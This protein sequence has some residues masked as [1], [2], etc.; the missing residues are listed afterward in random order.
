[1]FRD[2][3]NGPGE[4]LVVGS[5]QMVAAAP[6]EAIGK[7]ASAI[8]SVT[9]I[10]ADG[11]IVRPSVGDFVYQ[12]DTIET[13]ADGA[14]GI[15]FIDGTAFNVSAASRLVLNEFSCERTGAPNSALLSL[16]QGAFSFVAGKIAKTGGLNIHT[17]LATIRGKTQDRGIGILTLA[18]LTFAAIKESEAASPPDAFLDDG[19]ITYKDLPHGTFEITTRDGRVIIADDPGETIVVDPT[20]SVARIP[21][22]SSRMAELQQAQQT[23]LATLS[24]GQQ[25]AAP[26]GSST[27][28]FDL[29]V[30]LTPIN[31]IQ[32][33]SGPLQ[34]AITTHVTAASSGFIDV[35]NQIKP[36]VVI[37]ALAPDAG[38]RTVVE[39]INTTG[40]THVDFAPSGMLTFTGVQLAT[41]SASLASM[42]WSGGAPPSDLGGVLAGAFSL[43]VESGD[44][45]SGSIATTFGA[46]DR[47]FDFLA[48]GETLTIVYDVTVTDDLGNSLTQPV[49]ITIVGTNDAPVLAADAS[50]PH[51]VT[52]GLSTTGTLTFT[53]VDLN[54]HHTVTTSVVSATWSGGALPSGMAAWLAGALSATASDT[55]SGSGSV[56]VTFSAAGHGFDFLGAGQTLEITYNVTVTDGSGV[57][58][59]QPMTVTIAGTNDV[60]VIGGVHTGSVTEDINV[61]AGNISTSGGLT[62]TDADQGES[63]FAVQTGTL[64]SNGHGNFTLAADGTWT[65]TANN[66]QTAIQQLNAG[67]SITD[68]FTAVSSD[69]T[70]SQI[71]TVTITGTNDGPAIIAAT[72]PAAIPESAGSS[73]AQDIPAVTG[74]IT[75]SDQDVGDTLTLSVTGNATASYNGGA[76]PVEN[77]IDVSALIASGAISFAPLAASNGESQTVNWTYKPSA[78]DLDWLR[79]GDTLTLTYVAQ[80]DDGHGNVGA[81]NLVI[82]ITG[83]NDVPALTAATNPAAIAE[84][85]GSSSAQDIPAVTGTITVSD[86]DVGDT[87]TLSVT[88][89][90]TASYNGG[91][92]PVENSIDVS[93][94]IASGAISFAPLAASNGESQTVN[95]TYN[96]AAADLD[97]LRQGDTLTLTYVAQI[98]DGHGN[99]GAQNLVITITGTNDVP[100]ITAATNPA[101]IA[102]TQDVPPITGTITVSDQDVGDTLTLSVTGNA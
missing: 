79:Q 99:V 77:S 81:Q 73:S 17:P 10:R 40:S 41:A 53:D 102:A 61:V 21:N 59:S 70:A 68:S 90:A 83:T 12:G 71:V 84:S 76:L 87:L 56:A 98:D 29:P 62:I 31:F 58:S 47:T 43:T 5:V 64:G 7:I 35:T 4:G 16:V 44:P 86:Q 65:Y 52:Q 48:A 75:V 97:W 55:G 18:A 51:A 92:L 24:L 54:D 13:G 26:G 93:A 80:I 49:T 63:S 94:L 30:Q 91:A 6:L 85:A 27:Q 100:A 96:P 66:S 15:T 39:A 32:P 20:G 22:S 8:G 57:S 46:P 78:A 82:T 38:P 25:G 72:N 1:M 45:G 28:Q 60:P 33:S 3:S 34:E 69:G 67:Q 14:V 101:A 89:N 42:T 36:P 95:W 37:P 11:V 88:G 9:V 74:T 50:G 23:A 2:P 19:T